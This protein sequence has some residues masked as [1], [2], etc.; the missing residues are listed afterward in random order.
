M[1]MMIADDDDDLSS[2][3]FSLFLR[4]LIDLFEQRLSVPSH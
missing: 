2:L 4:A 1:M 3:L